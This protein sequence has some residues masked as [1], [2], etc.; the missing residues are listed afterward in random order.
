MSR[1]RRALR[2][3]A[4]AACLILL[5]CDRVAELA[6]LPALAMR[7]PLARTETFGAPGRILAGA[8]R[9]PAVCGA[10]GAGDFVGAHFSTLAALSLPGPLRILWPGQS[11]TDE[12]Q[13]ERLN[14]QVSETGMIRRL[15]CG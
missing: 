13:P 15:F 10:A 11:V 4:L 12:V 1:A 6:P 5:G 8:A 7:A 9:D 14:A 2:P 3:A